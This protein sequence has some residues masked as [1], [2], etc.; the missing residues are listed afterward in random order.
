M[1]KKPNAGT[2]FCNSY[3]NRNRSVSVI[4]TPTFSDRC[5]CSILPALVIST[6]SVLVCIYEEENRKHKLLPCQSGK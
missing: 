4:V 5:K 2:V 1:R 6:E 3:S